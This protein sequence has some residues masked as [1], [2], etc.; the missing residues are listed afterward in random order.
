MQNLGAIKALCTE[1][2]IQGHMKL[3]IDNLL[4]VAG[5]HEHEMPVL[6]ERLQKWLDMHKRVSLNNAH[7]LLAEIRQ[8]PIAV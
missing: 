8:T 3:H 5:A 4:L 2:I 7:D 1:G 6:K